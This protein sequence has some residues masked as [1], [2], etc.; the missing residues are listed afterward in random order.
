MAGYPPQQGQNQYGGQ[1]Q[2]GYPQ[3]QP[4]GQPGYPPQG[5]GPPPAQGTPG[6]VIAGAILALVPICPLIGVILAAVG[7]GEAKRRNAGVGL[8]KA[9]I[10]VGIIWILLSIGLNIAVRM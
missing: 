2:G 1:P 9:S 6:L 5:Y 4:Y 7:L 3:Q 8:A 10:I